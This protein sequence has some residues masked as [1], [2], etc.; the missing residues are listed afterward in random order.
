MLQPQASVSSG[1][2]CLGRMGCSEPSMQCCEQGKGRVSPSLR[3]DR[4]VCIRQS[5]GSESR[6]IPICASRKKT[7]SSQ[8]PKTIH[9]GSTAITWKFPCL[10]T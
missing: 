6:G 2:S 3:W 8:L 1:C 10:L 4:P 9:I 7:S 5:R